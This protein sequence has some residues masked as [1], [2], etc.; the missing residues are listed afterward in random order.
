MPP[1]KRLGPAVVR[2]TSWAMCQSALVAVGL[3][4]VSSWMLMN[5]EAKS[6]AYRQAELYASF[7]EPS[8]GGDLW[9]SVDRLRARDPHLLAIAVLG[10]GGKV[11]TI[12]PPSATL[13]GAIARSASSP[14]SVI[15]S[16]GLIRGE[17]SH[18]AVAT[19]PLAVVEAPYSQWVA[20]ALLEP[21]KFA[22]WLSFA[23]MFALG[24]VPILF[25]VHYRTA[26]WFERNVIGSLRALGQRQTKPSQLEQ[27]LKDSRVSQWAETSTVAGHLCELMDEL[28]THQSRDRRSESESRWDHD[29]R[30]RQ[31]EQQLRRAEDSAMTDAL[32]G[33]HNRAYLDKTLD[34]VIEQQRSAQRCLSAIMIDVDN[35]KGYNDARG[36]LAGDELLRFI[37]E[38]LRGTFRGTDHPIRYGGD[39]FLVL[40]PDVDSQQASRVAERII[41]MF[42]QYASRLADG[43]M[44]SLSAGVA[45]LVVDGHTNGLELIDRAD[46]AL[47]QGKRNGKNGV[48]DASEAF[49]SACPAVSS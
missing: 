31:L 7:L 12:Y 6:A 1:V 29:K 45:S 41:R 48:F 34:I 5:S 23:G 39:E 26:R 49:A 22:S 43:K 16:K 21:D 11:Q 32:T 44:L 28:A 38:L 17:R 46:H 27:R 14:G 4:A 19:V 3:F 42:G 8:P 47:Y 24:L 2:Q 20:V 35:F 15:R 36:H 33:L 10:A 18:F 40:L 13:R 9:A 37:G 30:R 25:A